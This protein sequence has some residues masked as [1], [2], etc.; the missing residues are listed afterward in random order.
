MKTVS[1]IGMR[2]ARSKS[3][4]SNTCFTFILDIWGRSQRSCESIPIRLRAWCGRSRLTSSACAHYHDLRSSQDTYESQKDDRRNDSAS[5][6][7]SSQGC[8]TMNAD[9]KRGEPSSPLS[10]R[11]RKTF[12]LFVVIGRVKIGTEVDDVDQ[13]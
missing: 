6:D 7:R 9:C 10:R 1:P 12:R 11:W 8:P 13:L 4:S 3:V 5:R 2:Y